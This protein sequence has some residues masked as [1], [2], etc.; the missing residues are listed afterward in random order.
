MNC[1]STRQC[2]TCLPQL[3]PRLIYSAF[4]QVTKLTPT[5]RSS[6]LKVG[7]RTALCL[8]PIINIEKVIMLLFS[9][10]I[11]KSG[12]QWTCHVVYVSLVRQ[13]KI[14]FMLLFCRTILVLGVMSKGYSV[15]VL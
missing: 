13:T 7:A 4:E 8:R 2:S 14:R 15:I 5:N 3:L 6:A 9:R 1:A 12:G 10:G 11:D